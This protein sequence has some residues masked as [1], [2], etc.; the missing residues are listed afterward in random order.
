MVLPQSMMTEWYWTGSMEFWNRVCR[1][2]LDPHAQKETSM[3]AQKISDILMKLEPRM[4]SSMRED[5]KKQ[6]LMADFLEM[7][8]TATVEQLREILKLV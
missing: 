6:Q 8:K 3:I 7:N 5:A 2:R 1:Q 4:W